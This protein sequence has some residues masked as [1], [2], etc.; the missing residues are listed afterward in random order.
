MNFQQS[1]K[2]KTILVTG[3]TGFK[4]SWLC[5][6][7]QH[8]GAR[9][10]GYSLPPSTDPNHFELLQL[11]N[12]LE[13]IVGDVRDLPHLRRVFSACKP[14]V[15]FHLAAQPL[16]LRSFEQPQETFDINATGTVNVLEAIRHSPSVKAAVMVTSDKCYENQEWI[17][18]YREHDRLGGSDPYSASKAMAELAI[19]SYRNSY[20]NSSTAVASVRAG[21][22]IGGGDFSDF[23][24]VPDC[25]KALMQGNPMIV[26]N[27]LS[28]RPWQHVLEPLCGYL[29]LADHLLV[30]GQKYAQAW[31]FGPS[32]QEGVTAQVIVEKAIAYWG[33]GTWVNPDAQRVHHEMGLL[34]LNWDKAAHL[35]KWKPRY[36]W[37]EALKAT[38]E[39]FKAYQSGLDMAQFSLGQIQTYSEHLSAQARL[40]E[41]ETCCLSQP[42]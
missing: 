26:R 14:D 1:F 4:G 31:N 27:P 7:L 28:V 8:L 9:V 2:G 16:V 41:E 23:R 37:E 3:H 19:S 5:L 39:W 29:T 18:G 21:N 24:L 35:L 22:V 42:L 36:T 25:M 15:V 11:E 32:E 12:N 17:W 38:V 34:R 10:V 30:Q 6:W 40:T 33:S 13:H 20:F